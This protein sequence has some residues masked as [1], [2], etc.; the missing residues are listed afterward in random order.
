MLKIFAIDKRE[1][2]SYI[3]KVKMVTQRFPSWIFL[4]PSIWV[5]G[6]FEEPYKWVEVGKETTEMWYGKEFWKIWIIIKFPFVVKI[7]LCYLLTCVCKLQ[8]QKSTFHWWRLVDGCCVVP[9]DALFKTK[10]LCP[11]PARRVDSQLTAAFLSGNW[12]EKLTCS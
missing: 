3:F 11:N 12:P 7:K 2:Q 8:F 6:T 1:M 4:T 9:H 10:I 5:R